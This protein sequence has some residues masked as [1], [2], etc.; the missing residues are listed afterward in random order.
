MLLSFL[1]FFSSS[2][3]ERPSMDR[4]QR[5]RLQGGDGDGGGGGDGDIK[6]L[7]DLSDTNLMPEFQPLF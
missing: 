5:E 3:G 7:V 4:R 1:L 6:R 2:R